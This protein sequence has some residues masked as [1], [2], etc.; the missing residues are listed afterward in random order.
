MA[1]CEVLLRAGLTDPPVCFRGTSVTPLVEGDHVRTDQ[2][3]PPVNCCLKGGLRLLGKTV[4]RSLESDSREFA[5]MF[6]LSN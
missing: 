1:L 2:V 4:G 5:Q 6:E 3:N